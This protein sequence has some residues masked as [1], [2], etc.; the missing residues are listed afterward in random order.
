MLGV[1]LPARTVF[2]FPTIAGLAQEVEKARVLAP[3]A[4]GSILQHHPRSQSTADRDALLDQLHRLSE[5]DA[6]SLLK[7]MLEEKQADDHRF[8]RS[9]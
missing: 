9:E 4:R 2:E 3:E 8:Q 5:Q 6:Q 7:A 1:E